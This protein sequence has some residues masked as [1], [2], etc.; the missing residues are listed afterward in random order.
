MRYFISQLEL[1]CPIL[2][3]CLEKTTY[4]VLSLPRIAVE[5]KIFFNVFLHQ[6]LHIGRFVPVVV[7]VM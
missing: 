3:N 7:N 6:S 5:I 4:T 1:N 2:S